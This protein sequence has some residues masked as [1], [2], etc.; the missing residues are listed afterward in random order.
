MDIL[1]Y[2]K[3]I[4]NY[5]NDK[6]KESLFNKE[7][8][9]SLLKFDHD[10]Q[11]EL[12]EKSKLTDCPDELQ[13]FDPILYKHQ[14]FIA[15]NEYIEFI[16]E[17]YF[18]KYLKMDLSKSIE[19]SLYFCLIYYDHLLQKEH[20]NIKQKSDNYDIMEQILR[21]PETEIQFK[22]RVKSGFVEINRN[23]IKKYEKEF[24]NI[25]DLV[26]DALI[27]IIHDVFYQIFLNY[28]DLINDA[29]NIYTSNN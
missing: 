20:S 6:I 14:L 28:A 11:T 12:L 17:L 24:N 10:S 3:F 15:S 23:F 21:N 19:H 18:N 13:T 4:M 7:L 8:I 26:E 25:E 9:F 2:K 16:N 29:N 5:F 1:K 22:I 27:Q